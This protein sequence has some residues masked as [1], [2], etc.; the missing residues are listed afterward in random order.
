MFAILLNFKHIFLYYV[1][2]FV[3]YFIFCY[4]LPFDSKIIA[5]IFK[6]GLAV[7]I[8]VILSFGPFVYQGKDLKGDL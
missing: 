3:L 7:L 1:P 8:P 2:A 6:L 4:V 5:R